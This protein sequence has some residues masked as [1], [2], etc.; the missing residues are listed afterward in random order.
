M[1]GLLF[2]ARALG[3]VIGRAGQQNRRVLRALGHDDDGVELHAVA[4]GDHHFALDVILVGG[5]R[6]EGLGNVAIGGGA[7]MTQTATSRL[8]PGR[9]MF[10]LAR[11][12]CS[13]KY[14]SVMAFGRRRLNALEA[15]WPLDNVELHHAIEAAQAFSGGEPSG[16]RVL[17]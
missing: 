17:T 16:A 8:V 9:P 5:G 2:R 6:V 1:C 11:G 12:S 15:D 7:V 4:H 13:S 3:G 14:F 10:R